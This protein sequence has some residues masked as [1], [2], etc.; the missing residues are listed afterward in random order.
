[1]NISNNG[2]LKDKIRLSQNKS[3]YSIAVIFNNSAVM[4][5]CGYKMSGKWDTT[6]EVAKRGDQD[7][8]IYEESFRLPW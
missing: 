2:N 8:E 1:M 6:G 7:A 5:H 3:L 4:V